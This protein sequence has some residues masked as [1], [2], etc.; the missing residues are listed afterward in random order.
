MCTLSICVHTD[1]WVVCSLVCEHVSPEVD[2]SIFL[3]CFSSYS[4]L[5]LSFSYF[6]FYC[7]VHMSVLPAYV[8][9]HHMVPSD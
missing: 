8:S 6:L 3:D 9:E 2:C 4:L 1:V 7:F 5:D